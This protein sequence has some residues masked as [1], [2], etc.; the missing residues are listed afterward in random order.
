MYQK[1]NAH[2]RDALLWSSEK[3]GFASVSYFQE[4]VFIFTKELHSYFLEG[5]LFLKKCLLLKCLRISTGGTIKFFA[6]FIGVL[7]VK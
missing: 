5:S 1:S 4:N 2:W 3:R 6:L 7:R